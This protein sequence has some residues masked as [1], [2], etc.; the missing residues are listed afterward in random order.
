MP[1]LR[2]PAFVSGRWS[3]WAT[4]QSDEPETKCQRAAPGRNASTWSCSA[5]AE[6][7]THHEPDSRRGSA[8]SVPA[9]VIGLAQVER[10]VLVIGQPRKGHRVCTASNQEPG[11]VSDD[12]TIVLAGCD[13]G[14]TVEGTRKEGNVTAG[15]EP[16]EAE[17]AELPARPQL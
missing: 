6:E 1:E 2:S 13:Q 10:H 14:P 7:K 5:T 9:E 8:L 17:H 4:E 12:W 3:P 16:I 15:D 11:P